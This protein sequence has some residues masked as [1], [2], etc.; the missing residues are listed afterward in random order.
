V[1]SLPLRMYTNPTLNRLVPTFVAVR[2]ALR[3]GRSRWKQEPRRDDALAWA[4]LVA[5]SDAGED[6]IGNLART[7]LQEQAAKQAL[8]WRPWRAAG[9]PIEGIERLRELVREGRGAVISY[10]HLSEHTLLMLAIASQGPRLFLPRKRAP[11]ADKIAPDYRGRRRR[12]LLQRMERT[13]SRWVGRGNAFELLRTLVESG[14]VVMIAVDVKG[15]RPSTYLGHQVHLAR[16]PAELAFVTGAPVFPAYAHRTGSRLRFVIEDPI[17]P[18]DFDSADALHHRLVSRAEAAVTER[19]AQLYPYL[20]AEP[21][22]ALKAER[23]L[24]ARD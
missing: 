5:R 19:L 22:K 17:S 2:I 6:E 23:K 4:H 11:K 20:S 1:T 8:F 7:A 3:V 12:E 18:A 21:G 9:A 16:G 13:G 15:S 14:E 24:R 10:P